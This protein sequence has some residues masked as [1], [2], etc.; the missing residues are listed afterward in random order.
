MVY[1][2]RSQGK[3]SKVCRCRSWPTPRYC[4]HKKKK[5]NRHNITTCVQQ[6]LSCKLVLYIMAFYLF[7]TLAIPKSPSCTVPS[8][9][10]KIFCLCIKKK[11][12]IINWLSIH[13]FATRFDCSTLTGT[14]GLMSLWRIL[15]SCTCLSARQ[16]CM[17]QSRICRRKE[18]TNE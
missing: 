10:R 14:C 17:N 11:S 13:L 7:K 3:D 5:K 6:V 16:I 18:N 8:L 2:H 12:I 4:T 1:F 15:Q 9:V